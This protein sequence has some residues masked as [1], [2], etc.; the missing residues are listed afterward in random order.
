MR[1]A[2]IALLLVA[3]GEEEPPPTP[4]EDAGPPPPTCEASPGVE[5]G[6]PDGHPEPLGA[7]AGEARAG[8]LADVPDDASGMLRWAAGDFALAN[9]RIAVVIEDVGISDEFHHAGGQVI[10]LARVEGGALTAPADFGELVFAAERASIGAESVTVLADGSDGGPAV[11]RAQGPLT[12]IGF[13]IF[14]E[15]LLDGA[16]DDFE[17][18]LDYALAPDAEHVDVRAQL[19]N[20]SARDLAVRR[21]L[22]LA[23]QQNRMPAFAPEQGFGLPSGARLPWA[24]FIEEGA[25]SYAFEPASGE[26][27]VF[28]D[29]SNLVGLA[30]D[31]WAAPACAVTE[32]DLGDLHVGGPGLDG[33]LAARSRTLD[34]PR[35]TIAGV[36]RQSDGAP[37]A[38]ARVHVVSVDGARYLTRATADASGAFELSVAETNVTLQAFRRGD[39][40]SAGVPAVAPVED[41]EITLA[42]SATLNVSIAD[43]DGAPIPARVQLIPIDGEAH[44]PAG[45]YGERRVMRGRTDVR[46]VTDGAASLR[47]PAT[48]HRLVVSYGFE[49]E[50]AVVDLDPADGE[51]LTE[52]VVLER[53]LETPGVLCGDFHLHTNRSFDTQ[54]PAALKVLASAAEHLEIPVRSDHE[55]IGDF[56]AEIAALGLTDRLY[57][58]GSLELTTFTF[59]HFGVFPL[60]PVAGARNAGAI[61]WIARGPAEVL[62]E[63]ASRTGAHGAATVMINHPREGG[64]LLG[65]F[66]AAGFDPDT[67]DVAVPDNW[68]DG[69]TLVEVFN[70]SDFDAN[71]EGVVRDWFGL[72]RHGH[73]AFAVGSSDSHQVADKPVGWPRTCVDVG[74]DTAP[75]LR[76]LGAGHLRDRM[77]AGASTIVGGVFVDAVARGGAGPGET[78]PDAMARETID[79]TV[80]A[81][82]WVTVDRLRVIVDGEVTETIALDE[83]TRDPLDPVVRLRAP[84]EVAVD[85]GSFVVLVADGEGDLEPVYRSRRP[86]GVTNPIFY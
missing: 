5:P 71:A 83:T 67:G 66:N 37:A 6:D 60:D 33:L 74:V 78:V 2:L 24:G 12:E 81:P 51:S 63:A 49:H 45:L 76:A 10:G 27:R 43:G 28:L 80:R 64:S 36:V 21:P 70:D 1:R 50:I 52:S 41:L 11:V 4:L 3:C 55:W 53:A 16:V 9:D 20:R 84:I 69:F 86:F 19:I 65:Y 35:D 72:L 85:P 73:T 82:S 57:S 48:P 23:V 68:Y 39:G 40:W 15:A 62:G 34:E 61:D 46:Y 58:M 38:G 75:E 13:L 77:L 30:L 17:F 47:V 56:E 42:P 59:G 54:D 14:V 44:A 25:T 31:T 18:A 8:R 26:L 22:L 29:Q 32:L 79:V 7:P